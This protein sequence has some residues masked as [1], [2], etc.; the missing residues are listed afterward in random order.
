M[1]SISFHFDYSEVGKRLFVLNIGGQSYSEEYTNKAFCDLVS[2]LGLSTKERALLF[3]LAA[4]QCPDDDDRGWLIGR[5]QRLARDA[6]QIEDVYVDFNLSSSLLSGANVVARGGGPVLRNGGSDA[7]LTLPIATFHPHLKFSIGEQCKAEMVRVLEKYFVR[8]GHGE[9]ALRVFGLLPGRLDN[10][11]HWCGRLFSLTAVTQFLLGRKAFELKED[12]CEEGYCLP[13]GR[14][15]NRIPLVATYGSGD[16]YW[17]IVAAMFR[18]GAGKELRAESLRVTAA[19][20]AGDHLAEVAKI[21][22]LFRFL[23][24][25]SDTA[26]SR[27]E[28]LYLP[29]VG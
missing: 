23:I 26:Q 9:L 5:A 20:H 11:V 6:R 14:Y 29:L 24:F 12:V 17:P 28:G 25:D 1:G 19:R 2:R 22:Y 16:D 3:L 21:L 18:N 10:Y 7:A 8:Y 15:G 13:A 4:D 27:F